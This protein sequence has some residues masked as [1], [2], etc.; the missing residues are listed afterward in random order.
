M[1]PFPYWR[2]R[3]ANEAEWVSVR[4]C[5]SLWGSWVDGLERREVEKIRAFSVMFSS[6]NQIL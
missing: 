1:K 2:L 6:T 3:K 4:H 5:F